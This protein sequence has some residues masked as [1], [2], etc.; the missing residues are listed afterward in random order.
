MCELCT[1]RTNMGRDTA[2]VA[3]MMEDTYPDEGQ[4]IKCNSC[5][6]LV[7]TSSLVEGTC[8]HCNHQITAPVILQ[9]KKNG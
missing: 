8:P 6:I 1:S 2:N 5:K 7:F 4:I 3:I 9:G